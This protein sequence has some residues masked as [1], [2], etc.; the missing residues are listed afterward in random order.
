MVYSSGVGQIA[1]QES[2]LNTSKC[3]FLVLLRSH[4]AYSFRYR[5]TLIFWY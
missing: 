3:G 2:H 4:N 1:E 5:P